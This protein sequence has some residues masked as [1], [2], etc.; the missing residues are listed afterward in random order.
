MKIVISIK[1]ALA[2]AFS[3]KEIYVQN[4]IILSILRASALS[5]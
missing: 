1:G 2:V 4:E 3:S 5:D